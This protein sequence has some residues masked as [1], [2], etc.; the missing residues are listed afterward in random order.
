MLTGM[1]FLKLGI[2]KSIQRNI[3]VPLK[4]CPCVPGALEAHGDS[5]EWMKLFCRSYGKLRATRMFKL[6]VCMQRKKE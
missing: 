1:G 6:P 2:K 5:Y 4:K 3:L